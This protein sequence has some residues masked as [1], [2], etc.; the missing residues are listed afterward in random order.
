MSAKAD[1]CDCSI[2]HEDAVRLAKEA[3]LGDG[4][5]ES[6]AYL[7]KLL[8]DPTRMRIMWALD[9]AE[10]C[11]C[12]IAATLGMT[13]SAVSHQLNTLKQAKMV[14]SRRE[15]KNVFY[16]HDDAHVKDIVEIAREH[17]KHI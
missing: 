10:L 6:V 1:V 5:L 8:S 3:M 17:V 16:S 2:V 9:S 13:K 11:T 12:D 4:E 14:K 15:G 7:F